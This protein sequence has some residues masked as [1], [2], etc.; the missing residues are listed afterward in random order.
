MLERHPDFCTQRVLNILKKELSYIVLDFC[1][2]MIFQAK[3]SFHHAYEI[4]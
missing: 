4:T 3:I 2:Q 1:I